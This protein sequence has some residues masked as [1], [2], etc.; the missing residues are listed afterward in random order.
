M[1][2]DNHPGPVQ[3]ALSPPEQRKPMAMTVEQ[4]ART[5]GVSRSTIYRLFDSGQ[6]EKR[7]VRNR[8]VILTASLEA[9]VMGQPIAN[10]PAD[11]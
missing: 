6:L 2:R 10:T 11:R 5:A 7:K 1:K 3:A 4:A 8:T 9:L